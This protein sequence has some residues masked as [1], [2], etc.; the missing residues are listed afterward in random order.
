M[1]MRL[2]QRENSS[3]AEVNFYLFI[4]KIYNRRT[5][6]DAPR[7]ALSHIRRL[8]A[9]TFNCDSPPL[10][11]RS[12]IEMPVEDL[13]QSRCHLSVEKHE[14]GQRVHGENGATGAT[15]RTALKRARMRASCR[16][17]FVSEDQLRSYLSTAVVD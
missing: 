11:S 16:Q 8:S 9:A 6:F 13:Y 1:I 7:V 4:Q 10:T 3:I 14:K 17:R 12:P 2:A 15:G 5:L